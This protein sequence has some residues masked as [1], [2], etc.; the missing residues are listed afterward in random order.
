MAKNPTVEPGFY[1][2]SDVVTRFCRSRS[3]VL[4]QAKIDEAFPKPVKLGGCLAWR[5]EEVEAFI[6]NLQLATGCGLDA[7]S[8]RNERA[9]QQ[10]EAA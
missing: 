5:R 1:S 8:A 2:I 6:S 10:A 4:T 7:V 3:W 9:R